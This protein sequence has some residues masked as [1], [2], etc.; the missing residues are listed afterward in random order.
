M[1]KNNRN[2][3]VKY[4]SNFFTTSELLGENPDFVEIT[5]RVRLQQMVSSNELAEI[6]VSHNGR[7]R[8]N[9]VYAVSPIDPRVVGMA[10]EAGI[11]LHEQYDALLAAADPKP[12]DCGQSSE[13][14]ISLAA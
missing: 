5:L 7:G 9:K 3:T 6:G 12:S 11:M 8:P 13:E 2:Q 1:R 10:K 14:M 4:P